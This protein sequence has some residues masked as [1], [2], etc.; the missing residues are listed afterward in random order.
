[1]LRNLRNILQA[2]VSEKHHEQILGRLTNKKQVEQSMQFPYRF[3]TAYLAVGAAVKGESFGTRGG[4]G[5]KAGKGGKGM[6]GRAEEEGVGAA[7]VVSLDG[8]I[9]DKYKK[10]LDTAVQ[11]SVESR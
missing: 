10:A 7:P 3:L 2:G 6:R 1:M 4:K 9:A 5:G 11:L 8:S